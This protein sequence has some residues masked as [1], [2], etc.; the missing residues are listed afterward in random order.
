MTLLSPYC[1]CRFTCVVLMS[2]RSMPCPATASMTAAMRSLVWFIAA[3]ASGASDSIAALTVTVSGVPSTLPSPTTVTWRGA[4]P[5]GPATGPAGAESQA[6]TA[7]T[8]R[9]ATVM[10]RTLDGF[11]A[12]ALIDI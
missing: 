12:H 9:P 2:L 4:G 6:E 5:S 7:A 3:V 1:G 8:S 10:T 11:F